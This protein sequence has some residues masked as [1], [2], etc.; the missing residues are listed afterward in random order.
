MKNLNNLTK[1]YFGIKTFF[2][3]CT[4]ALFVQC[5]DTTKDSDDLKQGD[6]KTDDS[7]VKEDEPKAAVG[8]E[9]TGKMA[10]FNLDSLNSKLDVY[11]AMETKIKNAEAKAMAQMEKEQ[12]K[13][14]NWRK[15]WEAKG[16]LLSGEQATYQREAQKMQQDAMQFEQKIQMDMQLE[17]SK[18]MD[19]YAKR[20]T[21]HTRQYAEENSIDVIQAYTYGQSIWYYN[22]TLDITNELAKVMNDEYAKSTSITV[23]NNETAE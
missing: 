15:R 7:D 13:I 11:K 6:E 4:I 19:S 1:N 10:F 8:F 5:S 14:T 18:I 9:A 23:D 17:Q 20:L 3:L 21:N 22:P 16:D 2:I 12:K